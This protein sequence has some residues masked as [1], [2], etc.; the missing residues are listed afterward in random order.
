MFVVTDFRLFLIHS[1]FLLFSQSLLL[2]MPA[3]LIVAP[4]HRAQRV[5]KHLRPEYWYEKKSEIGV[6][7]YWKRSA[8]HFV[9]CQINQTVSCAP[10][11]NYM[12]FVEI[13]FFC[14]VL[15]SGCIFDEI[16]FFVSLLFSFIKKKQKKNAE[17]IANQKGSQRCLWDFVFWLHFTPIK[18]TLNSIWMSWSAVLSWVPINNEKKKI[19]YFAAFFCMFFFHRVFA[20]QLYNSHFNQRWIRLRTAASRVILF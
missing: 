7:F 5:Y 16:G 4:I 3:N 11:R 9:G 18:I 10:C 14:V 13:V 8:V 15:T 19:F 12:Q 17:E 20:H 6:C 1:V 2:S